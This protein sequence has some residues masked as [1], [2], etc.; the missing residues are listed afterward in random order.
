MRS[1]EQLFDV[2][3]SQSSLELLRNGLPTGN[4]Q[5]MRTPVGSGDACSLPLGKVFF[6]MPAVYRTLT[7]LRIEN[8]IFNR[9]FVRPDEY[10]HS[11]H[12]LHLYYNYQRV[13]L[14][15][16]RKERFDTR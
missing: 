6:I 14:S 4:A 12:N 13:R 10:A 1:E 9:T 5:F 11:V 3:F 2:V 16:C 8:V 7:T 15:D